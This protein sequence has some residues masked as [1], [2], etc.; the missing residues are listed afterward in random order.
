MPKIELDNIEIIMNKGKIAYKEKN[1]FHFNFN[2]F[3]YKK[4]NNFKK[5]TRNTT[6]CSNRRAGRSPKLIDGVN[7]VEKIIEY[8][9]IFLNTTSDPPHYNL[10]KFTHNSAGYLNRKYSKFVF[11]FK[12]QLT[13]SI[14]S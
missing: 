2:F 13:G 5:T 6:I 1:K 8:K 3:V 14:C 7:I 9:I 10:I 12:N 11:W 4:F